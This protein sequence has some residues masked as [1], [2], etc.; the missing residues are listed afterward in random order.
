MCKYSMFFQILIINYQGL[1]YAQATLPASVQDFLKQ[2]DLE[3]YWDM[4]KGMG[5]DL[6]D[7]LQDIT[8]SILDD[9]KVAIGHQG[10]LMCKIK[11]LI[12][13]SKQ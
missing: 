7:T 8:E 5:F 6:L 11:E 9:M 3:C 12:S 13:K 1:S 4:F 10:K 2:L